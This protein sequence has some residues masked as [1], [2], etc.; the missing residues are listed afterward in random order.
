M[1][2]W[3]RRQRADTIGH[4]DRTTDGQTA[5]RTDRWTKWFQHIPPYLYGGWGWGYKKNSDSKCPQCKKIIAT[6]TRLNTTK[7]NLTSYFGSLSVLLGKQTIAWVIG[8]LR[9]GTLL[10]D[11]VCFVVQ[12]LKSLLQFVLHINRKL[13]NQYA[14]FIWC[15]KHPHKVKS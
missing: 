6:I 10:A 14:S 1:V 11:V 12:W 15:R 2:E 4:T 5:G 13:V 8:R 9:S 7:T 3:F